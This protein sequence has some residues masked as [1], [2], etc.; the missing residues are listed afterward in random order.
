MSDLQT[1]QYSIEGHKNSIFFSNLKQ[2]FGRVA[3]NQLNVK[4]IR[5]IDSEIMRH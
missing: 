1:H 3:D 2:K 5:T 4:V